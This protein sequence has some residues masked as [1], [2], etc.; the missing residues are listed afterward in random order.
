MTNSVETAIEAVHRK[1]DTGVYNPETTSRRQLLDAL[2]TALE[3]VHDCERRI[4][5]L[6]Q[7][8]VRVLLGNDTIVAQL[9]ATE[10]EF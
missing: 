2:G 7:F 9:R 8:R 6:E 4:N 5:R 1:Y 10:R 3:E